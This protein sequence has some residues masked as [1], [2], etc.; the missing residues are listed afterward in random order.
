ME[1]GKQYRAVPC[2][3]NGCNYKIVIDEIRP[4]TSDEHGSVANPIADLSLICPICKT[5]G[6]YQQRQT[7][8][9]ICR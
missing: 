1:R 6:L 3:N 2:A 9:L 5:Q 4:E 8:V 7:I